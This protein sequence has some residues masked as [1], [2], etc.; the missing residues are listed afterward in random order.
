MRRII[1]EAIKIGYVKQALRLKKKLQRIA[2]LIS[3]LLGAVAVGMA[4]L[5]EVLDRRQ[6]L[7]SSSEPSRP[8]QDPAE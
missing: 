4:V 8:L 3:I 2:K 1:R 5:L 7:Q 6:R